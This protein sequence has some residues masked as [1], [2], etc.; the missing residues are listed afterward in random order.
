MKK[1]LGLGL[2]FNQSYLNIF[3]KIVFFAEVKIGV[4]FY[5]S[6]VLQILGF[7]IILNLVLDLSINAKI[8]TEAQFETLSNSI[9]QNLNSLLLIYLLNNDESF[10][11]LKV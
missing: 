5:I 11:I 9:S 10:R 6:Q 1:Q 7:I 3:F 8:L 4:D 2:F